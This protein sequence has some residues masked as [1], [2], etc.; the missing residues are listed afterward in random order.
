MAQIDKTAI[1]AVSME[2]ISAFVQKRLAEK[3]VLI[4]TIEDRS[5][6]VE[7]GMDS[8]NIG[9]S[10]SLTAAAKAEG[11]GYTAQALTW[12]VDKL[13]LSEQVGVYV[14][15]TRKGVSQSS[16]DQ[17]MAILAEATDAMIKQLEGKVYEELVKTSSSSPDH[18]IDLGTSDK[19]ALADILSARSLLR[20]QEVPFDGDDVFLAI[21]PAEEADLLGL[22]Q[23]IDASKYG[24]NDAIVRGEIGRVYGFRVIVSNSVTASTCIAY[25]RTHC[26]FARQGGVNWD[27][28]K[29]L[30]DSSK[31]Y[32]LEQV[33]GIKVLDAG[34][35]GVLLSNAS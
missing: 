18:Q 25:H 10:S 24:N 7:E 11:A 22:D 8:L 31:Q 30:K 2:K 5:S 14:E 17:E 6:E 16:V 26:A 28:D 15:A 20:A 35:R 3:A 29:D 1:D 33:Y 27:Q 9:R 13:A 4:N 19:L 32:L 21:N 12:V 34:V 23:F